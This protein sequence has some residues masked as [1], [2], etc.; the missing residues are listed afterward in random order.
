VNIITSFEGVTLEIGGDLETYWKSMAI[1]IFSSP[2]TGLLRWSHRSSLIGSAQNSPS[3]HSPAHPGSQAALPVS[4]L[5]GCYVFAVIQVTRDL[6]P[7][8]YADWLLPDSDFDLSVSDV[9]LA[10]F[11]A[12]GH[13]L[14]R[15]IDSECLDTTKDDKEWSSLLSRSMIPLAQLLKALPLKVNISLEL[16]YPSRTTRKRLSVGRRLDLNDFVDAVLRNI[17]HASTSLDAPRRKIV[18]VSFS[19]DICSALNWKQPNYPVFFVSQSGKKLDISSHPTAEG[20]DYLLPS[21]I[22]AAVEFARITNLLG[23]FVDAELLVQVPSLIQGIRNAGLLVGI[24]GASEK[25]GGLT[26]ATPSLEGTPVDALFGDGKVTFVGHS[27][28]EMF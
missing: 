13:R 22:G 25:F 18:F 19:P 27:M 4:S 7:V 24:H 1:P 9:T 20:E 11:E 16:A 23:I 17:Y 8:V 6:H 5:H 28:Q 21:S 2:Q 12:L 3:A 14:G 26:T 10:Q 15:G